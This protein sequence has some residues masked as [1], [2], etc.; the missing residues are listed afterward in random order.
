MADV[1]KIDEDWLGL[2]GGSY[3]HPTKEVIYHAVHEP[4]THQDEYAANA[5]TIRGQHGIQ[6][7]FPAGEK[8]GGEAGSGKKMPGS[9]GGKTTHSRK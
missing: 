7:S 4:T 1:N 9:E 2:D 8:Y 6:H 5:G 3:A